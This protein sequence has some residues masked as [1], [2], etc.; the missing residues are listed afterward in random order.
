MVMT[1]ETP[2][3]TEM[4]EAKEKENLDTPEASSDI[5]AD[6]NQVSKDSEAQMDYDWSNNNLLGEENELSKNARDFLGVQNGVSVKVTNAA[7]LAN[8]RL[9]PARLDECQLQ[10]PKPA[11][12][13]ANIAQGRVDRGRTKGGDLDTTQ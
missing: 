9:A 8:T 3:D 6:N 13:A 1:N 11:V 7:A 12:I 2:K 10:P 4:E 5:A